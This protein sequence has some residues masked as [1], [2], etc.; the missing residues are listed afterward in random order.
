MLDGK[1]YFGH[2]PDEDPDRE[3]PFLHSP[4]LLETLRAL[5][6]ELRAY[7]PTSAETGA[8]ADD[9]TP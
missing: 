1:Q 7:V 8:D 4:K 6:K 9:A 3:Q 2:F 5:E